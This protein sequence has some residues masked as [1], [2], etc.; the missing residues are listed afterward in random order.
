MIGFVW[1]LP[2][3]TMIAVVLGTCRAETFPLILRESG[4]SFMRLTVGIAI[5]CVALEGL[6]F[7]IPRIF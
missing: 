2:I 4:L 1:I 3:L 6:L 7:V 5:V